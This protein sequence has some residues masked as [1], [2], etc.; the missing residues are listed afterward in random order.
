MSDD[1]ETYELEELAEQPGLYFNPRTEVIVAVDD[2]ASVDQ[3]AFDPADLGGAEW[4]RISDEIPI[5]EQ[6]RDEAL[7]AY[8]ADYHAGGSGSLSATVRDQEADQGDP[9]EPRPGPDP[10]DDPDSGDDEVAGTEE[11]QE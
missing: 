1:P 6:A 9:D 2:S 4:V 3:E 11:E 10:G 8:Q 5:D 7:E